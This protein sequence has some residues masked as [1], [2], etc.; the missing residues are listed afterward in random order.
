MIL[1]YHKVFI[2]APT[3]WWVTADAFWRQMEQLSR[4][5]I[6]PLNDY[7]PSNPRHVVI[8]FDGV[9]DNVYT[10]ALPILKRFNYPF[11][12]FIVG[13]MVGKDNKFDQHVEPPAQFAGPE[14]LRAMVDHGGRLQWHSRTHGNL[15]QLN[16][17]ALD[18][19]LSVPESIRALD[20]EGFKWFAY[21]HGRVDKSVVERIRELFEGAVSCVEGHDLDR[22]QLNRVTVTNQTSFAQSTVSLIIANYNYGRY[23]AEAI[24][25][26]LAQTVPPKEILFIDDCSLDDSMEVAKRYEDKIKIVRNEK[27]LGIVANF[28]KAA[29]L[30]TGD[31]ICFLGA[32]NRFRSDY[33][34]QCQRLLDLHP[35]VAIAYTNVALFG[36]RAEVLAIKVGAEQLPHTNDM[37]LWRFPAFDEEVKARSKNRNVMHGSSMFRRAAYEQVGGYIESELPEDWHLFRRIIEKGWK[38]VLCPD[39]LL[40]YRQHSSEQANTQVNYALELAYVRRKVKTLSEQVKAQRAR[41]GQQQRLD[42]I[43]ASLGWKIMTSLGKIVNKLLP[44]GTRRRKLYDLF[45]IS[46]KTIIFEGWSSFIQKARQY[47]RQRGA[48]KS[49]SG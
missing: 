35:D 38:A 27:N 11:E 22:Y 20:P 46:L 25:S 41:Q 16:K 45:L 19:E 40:E 37:F 23:A 48:G 42:R 10:Y 44:Q 47:L 17:E 49:A 33:V 6:V 39:F 31:Y 32:D 18:Q 14:Q 5:T 36:P 29:A 12:L 7:D 15:S 26:A 2:E 4:Y 43:Y 21:P 30:T 3:I 24:E 8:T 13:E 1:M 34:E 28:N 9:Y